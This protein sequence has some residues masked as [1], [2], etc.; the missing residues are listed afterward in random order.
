MHVGDELDTI[1]E[2]WAKLKGI[3]KILATLGGLLGAYFSYHEFIREDV[4]ATIRKTAE[5][6]ENS[7]D[8]SIPEYIPRDAKSMDSMHASA[9]FK[10][11]QTLQ[12][13]W[14]PQG[15]IG[16]AGKNWFVTG[17]IKSGEFCNN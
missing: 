12:P 11:W 10:V 4:T 13:T 5:A 7:T 15:V 14:N 17:T 1:L 6:I 8:E 3:H 2:K 9:N 16:I